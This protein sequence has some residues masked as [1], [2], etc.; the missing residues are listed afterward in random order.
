VTRARTQR[1]K[2]PAQ[3]KKTVALIADSNIRASGTNLGLAGVR[4]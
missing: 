1:A 2:E 3:Q 4:I